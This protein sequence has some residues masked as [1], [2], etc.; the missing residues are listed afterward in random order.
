VYI[1]DG[2]L[3][4]QSDIQPDTLHADTQGQST[5]VFALA[6]LLGINLMP[7]IRNW[8]D[9]KFFR[10]H[11]DTRYE[12]I[13]PLFN[14]VIDWDLLETHWQ[15]LIQVVLSI[16]AGKVLPSTLLRK[17]SN[18]S[19]KNRLYQA[20]RE[21]GRVVR[22][23]FLLRYI[24][25]IKLRE[26][27]TASTNKVEAYNGFSK[28]FFFGGDGVISENDPEE[29]EKR[30]KYNDLVAN[31]VIF[32]NVVDMT[33]ILWDLINEG[34]KFSREDLVMLSPYLTRHIKRFGEY[35]LD[36]ENVPPPIEGEIPV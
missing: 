3:K 6:Y 32:Q 17:L 30:I 24:S 18:E 13:D 23:V 14:D 29:Q 8:K 9:L 34:Y 21:L 10:P 15:D 7:R 28:W 31:A 35:V 1:I 22:T 4:N 2:L 12:H 26:Q 33:M 11:K 20:F 16:K 5:P 19:K 36:L 27:I 25:D